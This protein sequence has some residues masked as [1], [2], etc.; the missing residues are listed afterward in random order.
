VISVSTSAYVHQAK[1]IFASSQPLTS[2]PKASIMSPDA[3]A[4]SPE[5]FL[6]LTYDFLIIGGGTAGLTLAAR[7]SEDASVTVGVLE[8]GE[9]KLDDVF[10]DTPTMF[11]QMFGKDEYDW[12]LMTVP[13]KG[14]H[15][16]IHNLVRGKMLGGSSGLNYM[17]Y[18]SHLF[19]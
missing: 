12:K 13:Q 19:F 10:V 17:M 5:Q 14:N 11:T 2:I 6:E 16:K 18:T 4:S 9:N 3:I 8:A 1:N 15:G 7:L